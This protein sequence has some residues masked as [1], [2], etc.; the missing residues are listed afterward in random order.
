MDGRTDIFA[1]GSV[2]YTLLTGRPPFE[3]PNVPG[4][5]ARVAPPQS[6]LGESAPAGNAPVQVSRDKKR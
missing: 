5:L 1:L 3:A 4:V 6:I 2:A